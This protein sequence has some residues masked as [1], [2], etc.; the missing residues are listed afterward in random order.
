MSRKF[1]YQELIHYICR[2]LFTF[3]TEIM[4]KL[5]LL[6]KHFTFLA[7][8]WLCSLSAVAQVPKTMDYQILAM[9]PK[10]GMVLANKELTIRV[11]LN[12]NAEDGKTVWSMEKTVTSSKAG[13]CTVSLD[14]S[15]VDL[16][17]GTYYIKAF[18]DGETVGASQ[19][20]SVPYTLMA[21]VA[22][23]VSG[24]ITK[25]KL[26]GTW[27]NVDPDGKYGSTV[28]IFTF[29]KDGTFSYSEKDSYS[30][31]NYSGTWKLDR[32]GNIIF[33]KVIGEY[34]NK[35]TVLPTVYDS[36]DNGLWICGSD[37]TFY[38]DQEMFY[39]Q[40]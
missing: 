16:T 17:L 29:N 20:K 24:V 11:E 28:Y 8:L 21:D 1:A 27:K 12:L 26:I 13:V 18:V 19:I 15:D 35:K 36:D 31:H 23:R 14:F 39:K 22:N 40:D 3:K 25:S 4:K 37:H 6:R 9:H 2:S 32:L 34:D 30:N 7:F 38:Y 33:D 10:T 5:S